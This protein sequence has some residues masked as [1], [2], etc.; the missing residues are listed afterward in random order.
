MKASRCACI[1]HNHLIHLSKSDAVTQTF[2]VLYLLA[3]LED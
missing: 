3:L 1:R 2:V